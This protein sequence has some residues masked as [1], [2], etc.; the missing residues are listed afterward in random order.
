MGSPREAKADQIEEFQ[1]EVE[2][3]KTI[4]LA[5]YKG[6]TV[7]EMERLRR[8]LRDAGGH[9]RI[10]KNTLAQLAL[11]RLGI[12][13]L[14][15]DLGGQIAFVFSDRDAVVG[16]KVAH[17]F[18]QKNERFVLKSGYFDGRRIGVEEL[19]AL[20]TLPSREELQARLVGVLGA[21]LVEFVL[22]LTAPLGEFVATLEAQAERLKEG[23]EIEAA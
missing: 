12:A 3:A 16:T 18:S 22:T 19:R 4:I 17:E 7:A 10:I 13:E 14:D 23:A 11:K 21:S 8:K 5:E 2:A 15:D 9:V 6:I 20:A 1:G